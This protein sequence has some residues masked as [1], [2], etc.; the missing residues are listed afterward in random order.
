[1][2]C[3]FALLFLACVATCYAQ[4]PASTF[5]LQLESCEKATCDCMKYEI[6]CQQGRADRPYQQRAAE[7][8]STRSV[9]P[10]GPTGRLA[11][12]HTPEIDKAIR[13]HITNNKLD[14]SPCIL[15][16]GFWIG[17]G[18]SAVEGEHTWSDG[19]AL[20]DSDYR[21]WAPREPNNNKKKDPLG[22]DCVQL[23]FRFGNGGK[24]DDEYCDFRPKGI[25]CEIPDPH[26]HSLQ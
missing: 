5:T 11:T 13:D 9:L 8:C 17:L 22:Q 3:K 23:W 26:C 6:Y 4:G 21:N 15:R 18:D 12:L 25:V 2:N 24:W 7:L 1:M 19:R 16:Y 10:G 20:C 14:V